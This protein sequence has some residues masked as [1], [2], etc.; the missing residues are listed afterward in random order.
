MAS[1]VDTSVKHFHSGRVGAP[2]L[3][4]AEGSMIALLDAC[5]VNGFG[6]KSVT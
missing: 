2:V 3:T 5:V 6:L 1:V 4:G